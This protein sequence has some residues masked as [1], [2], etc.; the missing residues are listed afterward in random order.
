MNVAR[1]N[2]IADD[3]HLIPKLGVG[4]QGLRKRVLRLPTT[5]D[6]AVDPITPSDSPLRLNL[7]P[8][9]ACRLNG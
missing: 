9:L 4:E 7:N 2:G 5:N 6:D 1:T 3:E 8:A